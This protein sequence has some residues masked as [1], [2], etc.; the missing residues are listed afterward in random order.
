MT[1]PSDTSRA[2]LRAAA[3]VGL[4]AGLLACA[5][6]GGLG[7]EPDLQFLPG[8]VAADAGSG[9]PTAVPPAAAAPATPRPENRAGCEAFVA[10]FNALTCLPE[11]AR[12]EAGSM[13]PA[14]LD[15]AGCNQ[16]QYWSCMKNKVRCEGSLPI[17]GDTPACSPVC[18]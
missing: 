12:L 18:G 7:V 13:C 14:E 15:L 8:P 4:F 5:G 2:L 1:K 9:D 11:A 3:A 10:A 16:R 17:P 6:T